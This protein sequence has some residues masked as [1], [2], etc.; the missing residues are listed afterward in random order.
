M[1]DHR[2]VW[3]NAEVISNYIYLFAIN[4]HFYGFFSY[5]FA[6][7]ASNIEVSHD[8]FISF[9]LNLYVFEWD[10]YFIFI[11]FL[12]IIGNNLFWWNPKFFK[13]INSSTY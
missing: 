13:K 3:C 6:S 7:L 9:A 12:D 11:I 4:Y 8:K 10:F 5:Y 2:Q 1:M